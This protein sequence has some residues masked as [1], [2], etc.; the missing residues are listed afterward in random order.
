MTELHKENQYSL[1]ITGDGSPSLHSDE[2]NEAMHSISGAY[3][4][5]LLKHVY[6][7][8]ILECGKKNLYVLDVGFG[9][10]YN[11][12]A[13]IKEFINNRNSRFLHI[14]SLEK[15]FSFFNLMN[16]IC[17]GDERDALYT[18]LKSAFIRGTAG[19]DEFRIEVIKGDA[20]ISARSLQERVFDAVFHD[21]YSPSKNPELWSVDFLKIIRGLI[22]DSGILTTYSSAPQIRAALIMAGFRIG[23]GPSVGRKRE[24][25]LAS[26][27]D[28]ITQMDAGCRL[29]LMND[30][31][32]VPYRDEKLDAARKDILERRIEEMRLKT[33]AGHQVPQ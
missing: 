7:S 9:I 23:A 17:F 24:G 25:T 3:E 1:V 21:P 12:L 15:D 31:K 30:R 22:S 28:L 10:G 2:Y 5:A 32:A 20:R 16:G 8:R 11:A 14:V 29:D 33:K 18:V 26:V 19:T 4:E 13:L 6:P 27:D